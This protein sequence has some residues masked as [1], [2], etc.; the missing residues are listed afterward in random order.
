MI[1]CLMKQC[2]ILVLRRLVAEDGRDL[3]WLPAVA[4]PRLARALP[5]MLD[6]GRRRPSID[7]LAAL[8]GMSR[9]AFSIAFKR[10]FGVAPHDFLVGSRLEHAARLLATTRLPVKAIAERI[11]YRSRSHFTRAF[12]AHYG[13]DPRAWRERAAPPAP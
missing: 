2:L 5:L 13:E 4:D 1:R 7:S 10:A 9:S 11:G 12:K 6:D 8:A 3:P